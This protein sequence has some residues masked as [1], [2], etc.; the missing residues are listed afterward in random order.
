MIK[1]DYSK[2][3]ND[4]LTFLYEGKKTI[5]SILDQKKELENL[6]KKL[7]SSKLLKGTKAEIVVA[8]LEA[9]I[10]IVNQSIKTLAQKLNENYKSLA[11]LDIMLNNFKISVEDVLNSV[12]PNFNLQDYVLVAINSRIMKS[13][14]PINKQSLISYYTNHPDDVDEVFFKIQ[15]TNKKTKEKIKFDKIYNVNEKLT[16]GTTLKDS[17]KIV[18]AEDKIGKLSKP[19]KDKFYAKFTLD[20]Q[21]ILKLYITKED[22]KYSEFLQDNISLICK[23]AQQHKDNEK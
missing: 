8:S 5:A 2:L 12:I 13:S 6:Q 18:C 22:F 21:T 1:I 10:G 16:D 3:I 19:V 9:K 11:K 4:Y 15:A 14:K 20:A 7:E 23:Q 17:L